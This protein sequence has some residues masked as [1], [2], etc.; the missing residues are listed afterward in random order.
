RFA[1]IPAAFR[2]VRRVTLN[3]CRHG[4]HDALS[5][6]DA[7]DPGELHQPRHLV[8]VDLDTFVPVFAS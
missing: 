2:Q 3:R 4:G 5:S 8:A 7:A 6:S 1:A